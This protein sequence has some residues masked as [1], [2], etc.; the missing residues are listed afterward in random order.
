MMWP[1]WSLEGHQRLRGR[2]TIWLPCHP[3]TERRE[4]QEL[5]TTAGVR[6]EP[7]KSHPG[8][9]KADNLQNPQGVARLSHRGLRVWQ[10]LEK[11]V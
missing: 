8:L 1:P 3:E 2:P 5:P 9:G 10:E 11:I 6:Q 4:Q 7:I